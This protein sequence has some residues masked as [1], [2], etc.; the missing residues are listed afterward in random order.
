MEVDEARRYPLAAMLEE[1]TDP[2]W[3]VGLVTGRAQMVAWARKTQ[4]LYGPKPIR[5]AWSRNIPITDH[6][7]AGFDIPEQVE[8][9]EA[10]FSRLQLADWPRRLVSEL[11]V[12]D[13]VA[14]RIFWLELG[15]EKLA[16]ALLDEDDDPICL[17]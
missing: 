8:A 10:L 7:Q 3:A 15:D 4:S 11:L 6:W 13:E 12:N 16:L 9:A 5:I 2:I 17:D 1:L 14:G